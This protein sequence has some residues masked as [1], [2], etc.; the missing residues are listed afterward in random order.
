MLESMFSPK[1]GMSVP[2][3]HIVSGVWYAVLIG[4]VALWIFGDK[5]AVIAVLLLSIGVLPYFLALAYREDSVTGPLL[6]ISGIC[7]GFFFLFLLLGSYVGSLFA[8]QLVLAQ[9][10]G[11]FVS[12]FLTDLMYV[13]LALL[14]GLVIGSMVLVVWQTSVVAAHL[15]DGVVVLPMI[16]QLF[17]YAFAMLGAT[18][19]CLALYEKVI[20]K[21]QMIEAAQ[22]MILSVALLALSAL[23][24]AY[25]VP[26]M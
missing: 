12:L 5:A 15:V 20:H 17:A 16:V 7:I 1:Y 26:V 3:Y 10:S 18:I 22:L 23:V 24:R 14:G 4:L 19:I 11:D 21:H 8:G 25:Y 9:Q 2:A 13:G 6:F